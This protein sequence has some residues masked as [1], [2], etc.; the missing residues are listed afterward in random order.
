MDRPKVSVVI[1]V[2]ISS[3]HLSKSIDSVLDQTYNSTEII[4]VAA[5]M[6]QGDVAIAKIV[7]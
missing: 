6:L 5:N 4:I 2:Q 3:D 1:P 7:K